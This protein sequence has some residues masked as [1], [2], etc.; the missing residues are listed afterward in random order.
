MIKNHRE[1]NYWQFR[2]HFFPA[3][4]PVYIKM[5]YRNSILQRRKEGKI[6]ESCLNH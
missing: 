2:S 3:I 5:Y 6:Y 4:V 1:R